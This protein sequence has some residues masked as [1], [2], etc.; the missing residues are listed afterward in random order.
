MSPAD[1]ERIGAELA[2]IFAAQRTDCDCQESWLPDNLCQRHLDEW[3][4]NV[5][6]MATPADTERIKSLKKVS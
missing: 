4:G 6:R 5:M 3:Y 1:Q 2:K